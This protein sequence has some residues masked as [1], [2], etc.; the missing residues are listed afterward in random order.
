MLYSILFYRT[1]TLAVIITVVCINKSY[2]QTEFAD[3]VV[4]GPAFS[5][6]G[7]GAVLLQ[8]DRYYATFSDWDDEGHWLEWELDIPEEG[9]YIPVFTYTT[10]HGPVNRSLAINGDIDAEQVVFDNTGGWG[11]LEQDWQTLTFNQEIT[12]NGGVNLVRMDNDGSGGLNLANIAFYT[13]SGL[14]EMNIVQAGETLGDAEIGFEIGQYSQEAYDDLEAE[15][16]IAQDVLDNESA[17]DDDMKS[18]GSDLKEAVSLF[19]ASSI[20]L[21]DMELVKARVIAE[22]LESNTSTSRV[23]SLLSSLENDGYWPDIDYEDVSRTGWDHREHL[24]NVVYLSRAYK[25]QDSDYYLD[26]NLKNAI[27]SALN[28]WL[29]EDFTADNWYQNQIRTPR[30]M[31]RIFLIMDDSL[32]DSQVAKGLSIIERANL[33][34]SG[35]RPG[36]DL[37]IIAGTMTKRGIFLEDEELIQKAVNAMAGE[38]RFTSPESGMRGVQVDYSFQHRT[39]GVISTLTYGANYP[40]NFVPWAIRLANTKYAFPDEAS[41]LLIDFYLD[42]IVSTMVHGKYRDPGASNREI[43][44]RTNFNSRGTSLPRELLKISNYRQDELE[45]LIK[46]RNGEQE[47]D[48]THNRYFWRSTYFNHQR[49]DYFAS[50]RMHSN[51]NNNVEE[52]YNDEGLR[53][54]HLADGSNFISRTGEEYNRIFPVWDW[55][56]IPGTTV[57]QKPSLP[58]SGQIVKNGRSTF[59]GG[60]SDGT[61]GA[62]AFNF[63][64]LHDPLD[65]RKSWFFFDDEF[66][67]LGSGISS[68]SGYPVATTLNQSL[69]KGAVTTD[70]SEVSSNGDHD[71]EDVSW[72]HHDGIAYLFPNPINLRLTNKTESGNWRQINHQSWATDDEVQQD[73]FKLWLDHETQPENASYEYIVVP[74]IDAS[75]INDYQNSSEIEVLANTPEIQ[76]VKHAGLEISQIIFYEAGE[77]DIAEGMTVSADMQSKVLIKTSGDV[78][79]EITVS[80]P[81]PRRG[82]LLLNL[83]V[84]AK[85]ESS[86]PKLADSWIEE[87]GYSDVYY[88]IPS[89]EFSGKSITEPTEGRETSVDPRSDSP[90]EVALHQNYPNPFN[91][92]T[93]VSFT[94]PEPGE[95]TLNVYDMLGRRVTTL[96]EGVISAGIHTFEFNASALASGVY[97]YRFNTPGFTK[98]KQMMLV[99]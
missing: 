28:F 89:A 90:N 62:A 97:I 27:D 34:A 18:A 6:Q 39:D 15:I 36:G 41:K 63:S 77:I 47:P 26:E 46:I 32:S 99:K 78:V 94:M 83:K 35:A 54:H 91:P 61:Y 16:Q 60:V 75:E 81:G 24:E 66:V 95:A 85:I 42:G 38:I 82:E 57:V 49:P 64:S 71:L 74:G 20:P 19:E 51:I 25:Q 22:L 87:E 56:K 68:E 44:R 80:S 17:S 21:P 48:Y 84:T 50:V 5:D 23:A 53:N 12:L 7:G 88:T 4:Q 40:E 31:V 93:N 43:S 65:A 58:G 86:V 67:S 37:I 30:D 45:K 11:E 3:A 72:V 98:S 79:K 10:D 73:V 9:N 70:E 76:A 69:L 14:L 2:A 1:F 52:P 13:Y 96:H 59:A 33:D 29:E 55:Q 92:V 8:P